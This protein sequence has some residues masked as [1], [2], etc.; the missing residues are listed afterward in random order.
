M[1]DDKELYIYKIFDTDCPVCAEMAPTEIEITE[2]HHVQFPRI[3]LDQ[4]MHYKEVFNYLSLKVAEDGSI[5]LPVY[6]KIDE[7]GNPTAH[8]CGKQSTE[9]LME[10]CGS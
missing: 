1:Q 4:C 5:N 10:L 7:G 3:S 6:L 2:K 8:L 9:S